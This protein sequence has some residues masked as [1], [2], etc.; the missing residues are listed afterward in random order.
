MKK[1]DYSF[2]SSDIDACI[3]ALTQ[4]DLLH[5]DQVPEV[6][7]NINIQCATS[8]ASKLIHNDVN[9]TANEL[10]VLCCCITYCNL[11]CNG[12]ISIDPDTYKQCMKYV[13]SLN[14]LDN[15]LSSQIF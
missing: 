8:A 6:Q 4:V 7:R 14:K 3:F 12:S 13:F 1:I 5:D 15:E 11:I 9:L 2:S 10:R